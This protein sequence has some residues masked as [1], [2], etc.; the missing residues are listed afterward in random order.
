MQSIALRRLGLE[1]RLSSPSN[2][3]A[4]VAER[5]TCSPPTKANMSFPGLR[6]WESWR[7]TP[8]AGVFSRG[9]PVTTPLYSGAAPFSPHFTLLGFRDLVVKSRPNIS[10]KLERRALHSEMLRSVPCAPGPILRD[11]TATT[12]SAGMKAWWI[13]EIPEKTRRPSASFGTILTRVARPGIEPGSP[14]WEAENKLALLFPNFNSEGDRGNLVV[15]LLTSHLGGNGIDPRRDRSR[16][17]ACGSRFLGDIPFFLPP[18]HSAAAPSS[19]SFNL[20][21]SHTSM[22]R[23]TRTPALA[24]GGPKLVASDEP[25]V[26]I[27]CV[28]LLMANIHI[29]RLAWLPSGNAQIRTSRHASAAG[30]RYG[31]EGG[32]AVAFARQDM[33]NAALCKFCSRRN[34]SQLNCL[35]TLLYPAA[36]LPPA[37]STRAPQSLDCTFQIPDDV[38]RRKLAFQLPPPP[39]SSM[40]SAGIVREAGRPW[41]CMDMTEAVPATHAVCGQVSSRWNIALGDPSC[42]AALQMQPL[43]LQSKRQHTQW[44]LESQIRLHEATGKSSRAH[45]GPKT[46]EFRGLG[47]Q[48]ITPRLVHD[49]SILSSS[50]RQPRPSLADPLG[51][52]AFHLSTALVIS[53]LRGPEVSRRRDIQRYDHSATFH[54][55]PCRISP[56]VSRVNA[57]SITPQALQPLVVVLAAPLPDVLSIAHA[58]TCVHLKILPMTRWAPGPHWVRNP[59][60]LGSVSLIVL[61]AAVAEWLAYSHPIKAN[62]VYSCRTMPLVGG[63]TRGSSVSPALSFRRCSILNLPH[64]LS[65]LRC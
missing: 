54:P 29:S 5:L 49:Q 16:I 15:R 43:L 12:S 31:R 58:P 60:T 65:R 59:L 33:N 9:S 34:I 18:F 39:F 27:C 40:C 61:G 48:G 64:R 10:T 53:K 13:R 35:A 41:Q 4:A 26:V 7:M 17:F 23:A 42:A 20:T 46:G 19:P 63:F 44:A 22:L 51:V 1:H 45:M 14:W 21:R 3:G 2:L 50:G 32:R 8:L 30:R 6:K 36:F 56:Y 25:D 55:E 47:Q 62:W 52:R 24:N 37:Y 28:I 11:T 38:A 57:A